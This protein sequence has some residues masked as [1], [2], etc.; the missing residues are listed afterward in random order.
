MRGKKGPLNNVANALVALRNE[1]TLYNAIARDEMLCAAVLR[2]NDA[3]P[4]FV[5]RPITDDDITAIQEFLQ[6]QGLRSMGKDVVYQAV[7]KCARERAF[8]P[9]RD[10]LNALQW[11]DKQRLTTWPNVYLPARA[12]IPSK[13]ICARQQPLQ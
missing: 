7:Q 11:D 2:R 3:D 9:V 1:P 10:Y 12:P 5:P 6:W 4:S 13:K 8:H